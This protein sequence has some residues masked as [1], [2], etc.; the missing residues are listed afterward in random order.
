MLIWSLCASSPVTFYY[1]VHVLLFRVCVRMHVFIALDVQ[2][3]RECLCVVW[4]GKDFHSWELFVF[5]SH[6]EN[7]MYPSHIILYEQNLPYAI[8]FVKEF[9]AVALPCNVIW[10]STQLR[11]SLRRRKPFSFFFLG[12]FRVF[13]LLLWRAHSLSLRPFFF[14]PKIVNHNLHIH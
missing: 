11:V 1:C 4:R 2:S 9:S 5:W 10:H 8:K 13:L 3:I 14:E 6:V 7:G 12:G